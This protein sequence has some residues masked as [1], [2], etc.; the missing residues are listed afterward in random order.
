[1]RSWLLRVRHNV[2]CESPE[3]RG[4][5]VNPWLSTC[6]KSVWYVSSHVSLRAKRVL[7]SLDFCS[8]KITTIKKIVSPLATAFEAESGNH[9]FRVPHPVS[10]C[11]HNIS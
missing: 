8:P 5:N 6:F 7:R 2:C 11:T 9:T 10:V 4:L 3:L 1:M